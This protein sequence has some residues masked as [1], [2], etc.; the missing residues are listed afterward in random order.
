MTSRASTP[1]TTG[2]TTGPTAIGMPAGARATSFRRPTIG[3]AT[4]ITIGAPGWLE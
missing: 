4:V 1:A 2:T 3:T